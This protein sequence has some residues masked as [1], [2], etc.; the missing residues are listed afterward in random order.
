RTAESDDGAA[1]YGRSAI[2]HELVVPVLP[3]G[4][5]S[6]SLQGLLHNKS[7]KEFG[8]KITL[9]EIFVSHEL[10]VKGN[11][12]VYPFNYIFAQGAAH[13]I[14]GFFPGAGYGDDLA[15]H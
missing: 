2:G 15:D 14:D 11:G 7:V 9:P 1:G 4:D 6:A 5:H 12:G 13:G 8:G 10:L 3:T